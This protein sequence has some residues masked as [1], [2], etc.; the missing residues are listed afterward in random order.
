MLNEQAIGVMSTEMNVTLQTCLYGA[1]HPKIVSQG[2]EG[3]VKFPSLLNTPGQA[4]G[5]LNGSPPFSEHVPIYV[6]TYFIRRP[7]AEYATQKP[8]GN[9]TRLSLPT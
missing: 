7:A 9:L 2:G 1:Q 8:D 4:H 3:L 5:C 6:H